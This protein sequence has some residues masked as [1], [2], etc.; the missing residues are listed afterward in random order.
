MDSANYLSQLRHRSV[1][2]AALGVMLCFASA[3]GLAAGSGTAIAPITQDLPLNEMKRG[4]KLDLRLAMNSHDRTG[5]YSEPTRTA[6]ISSSGEQ[7][8]VDNPR[9]ADTAGWPMQLAKLAPS[10]SLNAAVVSARTHD[11]GHVSAAGKQ[12]M[13]I[14]GTA[15]AASPRNVPSAPS[16][17]SWD[18]VPADKTLNAA[19]A[20]WAAV[21]GWQ[22]LWELPVDYAVSVR[23]EIHGSFEEAIVLVAKAME[24]AEIP[25]KAIFYEGNRVLRIV[26]KGAE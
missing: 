15:V 18:V 10:N 26:A 9:T 2:V 19:L 4:L 7:Q 5:S 13:P 20:R 25:M 23:T 11:V 14:T 21:A 1:S 6:A 16:A 3:D 12:A 17:S 22:L 8:A 24:T